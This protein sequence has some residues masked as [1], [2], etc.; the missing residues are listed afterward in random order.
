[1]TTKTKSQTVAEDVAALLRARVPLLWVVT[2]EEARV[3]GYLFE[4][5]AAAGYPMLTW[6]VAQGAR[7]FSGNVPDGIPTSQDP[8][9]MLDAIAS[10][11]DPEGPKPGDVTR[12]LWCM[13]DLHIWLPGMPG[14]AQSRRLRNLARAFPTMPKDRAQAIVV[15]S[16]T[17]EIPPE[18]IGQAT[19]IDWPMPDRAE[20]EAILDGAL[21]AVQESKREAALPDRAGAIDAAVGLAGDEA[22]NCYAKSLVQLGKI[23]PAAVSAEKKR[24]IAREKLVEWYDPLP[25]G[26]EAVGGLEGIKGWLKNRTNAYSPEARA[27]GLPAPKGI[28]VLGVQGCGKSLLSKAV[29]TFWQCPL[30]RLD[31]NAL[32]SKFVGESE[33]NLRKALK[34]IEAI[35]RCV[36]WIDEIEKALAG[37]T[38]GSADGGVSQ[39]ALGAI[40]NW[41]QERTCEAFVI[42][43]AN[44]V[45]ALPPEL[46]RKGRFDEVFFVDLPQDAERAAILSAALRTHGRSGDGKAFPEVVKA[47]AGFTGSEV[48]E[49]VVDAMYRAFADGS[50]EITQAD[51]IAAASTVVPLSKSNAPKIDALR[52]WQKQRGARPASGLSAAPAAA[53]SNE[54]VLDVA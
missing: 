15:L 9:E 25:G 42:A 30:L 50:R 13:R 3:E 2:R 37:A 38:S 35:G 7:D 45:T 21:R 33:G 16:P 10:L 31:L 12:T 18:L 46:M 26:L 52:D 20:I 41:M 39:D 11:A 28:F 32:K 8:G 1:M 27:Y 44:D 17:N 49:I 19:V 48:A 4:A 53:R 22:G 47:T 14:A 36:I 23:D 5:A 34:M 24:I 29:A 43:T 6:D 40:L 51:L 54:R